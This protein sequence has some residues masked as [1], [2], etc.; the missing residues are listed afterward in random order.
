MTIEIAVRHAVPGF[1]LDVDLRLGNGLNALFG[2]SGSGKTTLVNVIAGLRRPGAGRIVVDGTVLHDS[3]AGLDLPRHRRR[4]GYVFQEA[5]LFPHLDVRRNLL[6]GRWLRGQGGGRAEI[7]A[8][9]EMLGIG[10]LLARRPSGLSGGEKQRVAIGRA[11][12]SAP[13]LLLMDEPLTALDEARKAEIMPYLERLRDESRVPI[14]YVSHSV[15]EV[16]RLAGEMVALSGGRVVAHGPTAEVMAGLDILPGGVTAEAGVMLDAEVVGT[17]PEWQLTLLDTAA[18][19]LA[20]PSGDLPAAGRVRLRIRAR[21]VM[22]ALDPPVGVSALNSLPGVVEAVVAT[23]DSAVLL[24]LRCNT[25]V[26]FARVTRRSAAN[27]DLVPGRR[28]HAV[29]KSVALDRAMIS[30]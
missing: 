26:V 22:L 29:L 21:D 24:R 28:V 30:L 13:R 8:V 4:I 19:R 9:V 3:A 27:L 20:V 7:D 10:S 2:P 25:A 5:R 23:G 12:L 18:G 6:Y 15:A 17:E 14:L 11:L 1:T 16:G